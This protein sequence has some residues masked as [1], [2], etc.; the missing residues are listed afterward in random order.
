MSNGPGKYNAALSAA[1]EQFN[2]GNA[3]L[4]V[5][6]GPAGPG[7][8]VQALPEIVRAMPAMLRYMADEIERDKSWCQ[9]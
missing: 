6:D 1:R 5:F 2:L 4:I 9:A 7:F 8:E 3:V